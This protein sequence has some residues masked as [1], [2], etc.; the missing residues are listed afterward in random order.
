MTRETPVMVLEVY[1]SHVI[2]IVACEA[3]TPPRPDLDLFHIP[4]ACVDG[5]ATFQSQAEEN[6]AENEIHEQSNS[7]ASSDLV[8]T[9]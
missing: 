2:E 6:R 5:G 3:A 1:R 7:D 4:D 8:H 9:A